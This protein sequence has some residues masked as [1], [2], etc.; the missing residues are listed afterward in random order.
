M[1]MW[2]LYSGREGVAVSVDAMAFIDKIC[3]Y[4]DTVEDP[5]IKAAYAGFVKYIDVLSFE[6][7]KDCSKMKVSKVALRKDKSY[8]HEKEF[9]IVLRRIE[10]VQQ[11]DGLSNQDFL[12]IPVP[13]FNQ[14]DAKFYTH[15]EMPL[16]KQYCV[17]RM[18]TQNGLDIVVTPSRIPIKGFGN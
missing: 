10:N 14:L 9:R 8:E 6:P 17:E 4:L 11:S 7:G 13:S 3:E 15:P 2:N 5:L 1:A 16:W 12:S 18:A